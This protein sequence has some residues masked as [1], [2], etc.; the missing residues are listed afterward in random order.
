MGSWGEEIGRVQ[1]QRG[2]TDHFHFLVSCMLLLLGLVS[3]DEGPLVSASAT[4]NINKVPQSNLIAVVKFKFGM[5][6]VFG[7]F[8][9]FFVTCHKGNGF[10]FIYCLS[11]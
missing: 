5:M 6:F 8:S 11:H 4:I 7:I 10:C 2:Q 3:A 1:G 9:N